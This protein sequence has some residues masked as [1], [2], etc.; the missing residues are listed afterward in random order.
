[1][2]QKKKSNTRKQT[3]VKRVHTT[4]KNMYWNAW[5]GKHTPT[6]TYHIHATKS[7]HFDKMAEETKS[8]QVS[9]ASPLQR[10]M[11]SKIMDSS[12]HDLLLQVAEMDDDID[13]PSLTKFLEDGKTLA[14]FWKIG[15]REVPE[16][17]D[18]EVDISTP[19]KARDYLDGELASIELTIDCDIRELKAALTDMEEEYNDHNRWRSRVVFF[20]KQMQHQV[21]KRE[22]YPWVLEL[23]H[24]SDLLSSIKEVRGL[25]TVQRSKAQKRLEELE[26]LKLDATWYRL[27]AEKACETA[28][29][30]S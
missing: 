17:F 22:H 23:Q 29:K 3:V 5:K 21:K 4:T 7:N 13:Y 11:L 14:P 16:Y 30:M 26:I 24:M 20:V 19:N 10:G 27:C 1:M 28:N 15:D 8:T 2:T 12:Q 18:K 25:M 6:K 9:N